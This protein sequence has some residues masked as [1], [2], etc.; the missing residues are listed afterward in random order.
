MASTPIPRRRT[1]A[2]PAPSDNEE[3]PGKARPSSPLTPLTTSKYPPTMSFMPLP[4]PFPK[5][6]PL[7]AAT[8][9]TKNAS[10][11]NHKSAKPKAAQAAARDV[12]ASE[13]APPKG[14]SGVNPQTP[15][16][17]ARQVPERSPD[18]N[19]R[20]RVHLQRSVTAERSPSITSKRPPM[21]PLGRPKKINYIELS[22]EDTQEPLNQRRE[23]QLGNIMHLDLNYSDNNPQAKEICKPVV[24]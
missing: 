10:A 24:F 9:R 19:P 18:I 6:L 5:A 21:R 7:K 20:S 2:N 11:A 22:D 3:I 8:K 4:L 17:R 15:P 1:R 13:R 23:A 16:H 14:T 12:P